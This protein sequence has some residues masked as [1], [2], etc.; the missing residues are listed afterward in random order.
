MNFL[1][2]YFTG[3]RL[4]HEGDDGSPVQAKALRGDKLPLD[5]E[6]PRKMLHDLVLFARTYS[7]SKRRLYY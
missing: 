3:T 5:A 4:A 6:A 7:T 2:R 1:H